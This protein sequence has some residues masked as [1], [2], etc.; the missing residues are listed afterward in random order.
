MEDNEFY[1][2]LEEQSTLRFLREKFWQGRLDQ[3]GET[4]IYLTNCQH[5]FPDEEPVTCRIIDPPEDDDL[6]VVG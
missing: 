4:F 2:K 6:I 1:K 3:S 5:W